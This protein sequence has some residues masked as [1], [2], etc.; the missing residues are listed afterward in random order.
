MLLKPPAESE[1]MLVAVTGA[2]GFLGSYAAVALRHRGHRVRGLVRR[3]DRLSRIQSPLDESRVGELRQDRVRAALVDG[4]EAVVHLAMD[5]RA[6]SEGAL[7]GME[8]NLIPTLRLMEAAHR[9][10]VRQFLFISSLDVYAGCTSPPP[11]TEDHMTCPTSFYGAFKA[12]TEQYLLAYHRDTRMNTSAWRPATMYGLHPSPSRSM[13]AAEIKAPRGPVDSQTAAHV[14]HVQDVA[15]ALTLALGD[16][17]V[18][19]QVYNLVDG[20]VGLEQITRP[21]SESHA[22]RPAPAQAFDNHKSMAF[23]ER[24]GETRALRRGPAGVRDYA[25]Q[26]RAALE[27]GRES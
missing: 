13:W 23:F 27:A 14:V 8:A 22:A 1:P 7:T 12:A 9:A 19:G 21:A 10:G 17:S 2:G 6:A 16:D 20:Y 24:H 4:A 15:D 3:A 11:L 5:W 25:R 26:L 18:A